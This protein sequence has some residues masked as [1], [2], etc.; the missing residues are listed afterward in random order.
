[1]LCR[2]PPRFLLSS[3]AVTLASAGQ[4]VPVPVTFPPC[5]LPPPSSL[6]TSAPPPQGLTGVG[7]RRVVQAGASIMLLLAVLGKFG[8]LFASLPF[9]IIS[10]LF[11]CV[12]GIIASVGAS[13][14]RPQPQN[15]PS[16]LWH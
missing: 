9:A 1:M 11:C 4:L 2:A 10:G 16:S 15:P 7:S 13:T 14:A 8:G 5:K 6:P 3:P 12:F